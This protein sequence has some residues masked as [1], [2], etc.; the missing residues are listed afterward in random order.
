MLNIMADQINA[1]KGVLS[2]GTVSFH[3]IFAKAF[4]SIPAGVFLSQGYFW[5]ENA[6]YR[7]KDKYKTVEGK[8]FFSMTAKEWFEET[9]LTQEQQSGVRKILTKHKVLIEWLTD[10]PAKLYFH[11]DLETLV[12]VI[13]QYLESGVSVSVDNRNKNRFKTK[14]SLGKKRKQD[15]VKNLTSYNEESI[16]SL[17]SEGEGKHTPAPAENFDNLE[18]EISPLPKVAQKGFAPPPAEAEAAPTHLVTTTGPDA[19]GVRVIEGIIIKADTALTYDQH[20]LPKSSQ[21]LKEALRNYFVANPCEWQDGVLE[22]SRAT[23]WTPEKIG[24]CMTA[25]CAHQEGEGNMKRTY[26]QY[27]GMLVKWFLGERKF[28]TA[29]PGASAQ[30]SPNI[31]TVSTPQTQT[32]Y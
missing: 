9:S 23:N 4:R 18:E 32:R 21:E 28:D 22:Q 10:N 2:G 29:K 26:G 13:N 30:Q 27:K 8:T 11:I 20:P 16:E 14:T 25:F 31:V 17:E 7:D 12:L 3:A 6:K 1:L 24:D 5:Q 19:L 15:S